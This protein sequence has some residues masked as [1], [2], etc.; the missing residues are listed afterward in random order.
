MGTSVDMCLW[1]IVTSPGFSKFGVH[2]IASSATEGPKALNG[3]CCT[4]WADAPG[5]ALALR[6]L[7]VILLAL[8]IYIEAS[9]ID[10]RTLDMHLLLIHLLV[11]S[12]PTTVCKSLL[13]DS[14]LESMKIR[15]YPLPIH[16]NIGGCS[17]IS[18]TSGED[19]TAVVVK[20]TM[21]SARIGLSERCS[22][23]FFINLISSET[24]T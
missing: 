18:D 22:S 2:K 1:K 21:E 12:S 6:P 24:S 20:S 13:V 5:V 4:R 14:T 8:I 19:K 17:T 11:G 3:L 9:Y 23:P 15:T 7:G 16:Q 10:S